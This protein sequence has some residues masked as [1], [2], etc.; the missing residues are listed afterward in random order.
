MRVILTN[1]MKG[2][3][4]MTTNQI[5]YWTLQESKRA[6]QARERETNRANLAN[7]EIKREQNRIA[8]SYNVGF[9]SNQRSTIDE[10][11]RANQA[12]EK[13]LNRHQLVTEAQTDTSNAIQR[14][15]LGIDQQ[16]AD[17]NRFNSRISAWNAA[18]NA[19]SLLETNR[20]NLASEQIR[21]QTLEEQSRH[22]IQLESIDRLNSLLGHTDKSTTNDIN[23]RNA[24]TSEF[25]AQTNRKEQEETRR[26]NLVREYLD[27]L[28]LQHNINIDTANTMQNYLRGLRP[29][30]ITVK[31]GGTK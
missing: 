18:T 8:E 4:N 2:G 1:I 23:S 19:N 20:A 12:K 26:S 14:Q 13:E 27:S 29:S 28:R 21:Q 25:N 17:T 5:N 31:K 16:N 24:D 3:Q 15:K 30:R 10:T 7:E 11:S 22:N 9:L 6:N